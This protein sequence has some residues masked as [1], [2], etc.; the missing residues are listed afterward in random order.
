M[1]SHPRHTSPF[2]LRHPARTLIMCVFGVVALFVFS[3]AEVCAQPSQDERPPDA[4]PPPLKYIPSED[5]ARLNAEGDDLKDRTKLSLELA[6]ARLHRAAGRT[7]AGDYIAAGTE[8]GIYQALI[9]DA[10]RFLQQ[11]GTRKDNGSIDNKTRDLFKRLELTLRNHAPRI[12]TIRRITPSDEAYNVKEAYEFV[13][14]ARAEAL[15]SFYDDTVIRDAPKEKTKS[16]GDGRNNSASD[17]TPDKR[18]N[19]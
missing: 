2:V 19:P 10:I 7:S 8:L 11:K 13:R 5:G 4:A 17:P 14:N 18:Q 9:A 16:P 3:V 15:N 12:E 1:N 6:E